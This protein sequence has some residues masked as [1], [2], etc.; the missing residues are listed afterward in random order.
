NVIEQLLTSDVLAVTWQFSHTVDASGFTTR[1]VSG[2]I[3]IEG[4]TVQA[5]QSA[6][7]YRAIV[8]NAIPSLTWYKFESAQYT[9]SE[10]GRVLSFSVTEVEQNWTLPN[11]IT[12]GHVTW[13]SRLGGVDSEF[14]IDY[15]LSGWFQSSAAHSKIEILNAIG[16]LA[17][18]RFGGI[19]GTLIPGERVIR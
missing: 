6:D 11:P 17:A 1:T 9:Q 14:I 7:H 10:D 2:K 13:A 16:A 18:S 5:G 8:A 3:L 15:T 12:D 19:T 4:G